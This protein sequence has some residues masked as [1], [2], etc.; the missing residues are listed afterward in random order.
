MGSAS[1]SGTLRH[2]WI[3]ACIVGELLGFVPP[4]L[5]GAVLV[6]LDAPEA[7]LV[8]G[9][10]LSG[11]AEGLVLGA[12]Q[13]H[14]LRDALPS[15]TGWVRATTTAAGLAWLAGMGGSSLIQAVGPW[16]LL[17]VAPGWIVGLLSMGV[18][19][20]RRLHPVVTDARTWIPVTTVAW[21]IGVAIPVTALS[22]V[23]NGW[24]PTVHV[25]VAIGAAVAMGATVGAITGTT[26]E[27]FATR[28][29]RTQPRLDDSHMPKA[30][31]P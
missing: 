29:E 6:V 16:A 10:V 13:S 11:M 2:R 30:T 20:S 5:T 25:V 27:R 8:L 3:R 28:H 7:V 15:V 22:V 31:R 14:V 9:L 12:A 21:L 24:P 23:P 4:A 26:L 18:L 19:Q 17:V 1:A